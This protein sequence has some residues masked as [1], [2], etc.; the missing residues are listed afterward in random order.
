MT[1][2]TC[3]HAL[4]DD[5]CAKLEHPADPVVVGWVVEG[6]GDCPRKCYR[7]LSKSDKVVVAQEN[8]MKLH[9]GILGAAVCGAYGP[10]EG[11]TDSLSRVNC[12][13]C[14]ATIDEWGADLARAEDSTGAGAVHEHLTSDNDDGA[15]GDLATDC[16]G[17]G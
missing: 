8:R 14:N 6:G 11:L 3:D 16:G 1:C 15:H 12:D 9:Y 13:D 5:R 17:E 7:V 10:N 2:A 4:P